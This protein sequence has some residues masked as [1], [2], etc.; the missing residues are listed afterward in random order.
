MARPRDLVFVELKII[1]ELLVGLT[2]EQ[3]QSSDEMRAV[4][5]TLSDSVSPSLQ[6]LWRFR[7][8][9]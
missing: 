5:G 8:R 9:D 3:Q 1:P 6:R 4:Q 2:V 7:I